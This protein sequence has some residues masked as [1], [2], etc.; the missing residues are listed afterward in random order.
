MHD[1]GV[2]TYM[3]SQAVL[4]A[5]VCEC[6]MR[7]DS[8]DQHAPRQ[9]HTSHQ[10]GL[11]PGPNPCKPGLNPVQARSKPDLNP[12]QTRSESSLNPVQTRSESSL[13]PV[14]TR[15]VERR[16]RLQRDT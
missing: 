5:C 15:S 2:Q 7:R 13:N 8:T 9:P 6:A 16:L 10:R 11:Q 14:Q 4:R 1:A 12:V 3:T